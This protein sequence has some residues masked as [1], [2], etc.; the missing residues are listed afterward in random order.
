MAGKHSKSLFKNS[1]ITVNGVLS[2]ERKN[3]LPVSL[4][5]KIIIA[6]T[7]ISLAV[8]AFL[9]GSY[10]LPGKLQE[11]LL[12][13][14][15]DTFE[16][17][18]NYNSALQI[19]AKDNADI[20]GWLKAGGTLINCAVC[21][22]DNDKYYINHN[23]LGKKSRYGALFLSSADSFER[24]GD[25]RNI[26]IYGNNMKNGS[27]FG[28][29]K[30]YR[31]LNFYKQNPTVE[32]YY[33]NNSETYVIF[34]VMLIASSGDDGGSSYMP[35]KGHFTDEAEFDAWYTETSRRS[36]IDT[37]VKPGYGDSMLTLVTPA[38]DFSGARLTVIAYRVK[39]SE[40]KNI[41]VTAAAVNK[42]IKYPEI[43]YK[44]RG[45]KYPY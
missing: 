2:T 3:M 22:T 13:K 32:L 25:D 30:K 17:T 45:L 38:D 19:L 27:M 34:A 44:N 6:V 16:S 1:G 18:P 24:T 35:S 9:V 43:W 14:A 23:Q 20:K 31:N 42:N 4:P 41:D 37:T 5:F 40:I 33:K 10:F 8:S 15:A 7:V 11:N 39:N 26:V 21:Q 29:L 28:N 36:L 12:K